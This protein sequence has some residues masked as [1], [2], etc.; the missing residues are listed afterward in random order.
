MQNVQVKLAETKSGLADV[1]GDRSRRLKVQAVRCGDMGFD[2]DG[3]VR[4]ET[5]QEV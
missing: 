5:G 2:C 3:G 4:A 1:H